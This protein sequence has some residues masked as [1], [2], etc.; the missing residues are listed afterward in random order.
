MNLL[1][2]SGGGNGENHQSKVINAM[3]FPLI[4]LVVL[5]HLQLPGE[6]LTSQYASFNVISQFFS[7]DG[8]AQ[9]AVPTFFY[10][11]RLLLFL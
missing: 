6:A 10:H 3:R 7:A 9:L 8:I 5:F 4:T 11:F 1:N 2:I